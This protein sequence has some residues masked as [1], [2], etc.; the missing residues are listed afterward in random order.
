[1][2]FIKPVD[3]AP[4]SQRFGNDFQLP[5]GRWYNKQV[6]GYKGHNGN[7][8]AAASGTPVK[9]A[10]EGT[11]VFEGWGQNHSWM[12]QPAGI[13]VLIDNGGL[14]SGYAHLSDTVVNKGQHVEKGQ[15]IGHVGST[16]AATGPH[17]HFEALPK[18]PNFQNGFVGRVD[19]NPYFEAEAPTPQP[20]AG[21]QRVVGSPQGA[22][23]RSGAG[24]SFAPIQENG[25]PLV[26]DKGVVLN[27]KGYVHG[28]AV[29]GSDIWLVGISGTKYIHISNFDDTDLHDLSDLTPKQEQ[30]TT[31]I[32]DYSKLVLDVSS[33]QNDDIANHFEKFLGVIVRVGHVGKSYGGGETKTDPKYKTFVQ[34]A[35]NADK[36]LGL[37]WLPYIS[38]EEDAK[39]EAA[40]FVAAINEVGN[41]D[42]EILFVDL[43]PDFEGTF[44]QLQIFRNEVFKATGKSVCV[45]AGNTIA[46]KL[47]LELVQ[48]YPNYSTTNDYPRSAVLHQYTST[49]NV[50]GYTG[51]LD[52]STTNKP[53]KELRV[54][55]Q[56]I[57]PG[58]PEAPK[59]DDKPKE[60]P[61]PDKLANNEDEFAKK[62][63]LTRKEHTMTTK[64]SD[65]DFNKMKKDNELVETDGW[66]PTI[67]D[68]V[69]LV[70]YLMGVIGIPIT[71]MTMSLLAVFGVVSYE[72][73]NQVSTIIASAIG[74]IASA[75]G[76]SH[77]TRGKQ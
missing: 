71:V 45:Y 27:F 28:Q 50:S 75:L 77:F 38:T 34:A 56:K 26:Y 61:K 47:G 64:L 70:V 18:T 12:G 20:L 4:I 23:V 59:T 40:R 48:W 5:D 53:L 11:V 44:Q 52:F 60:Q 73:S 24:T 74:T 49:G 65:E 66:K 55:G 14:Y 46:E 37:Y 42:G 68:N 57:I 16:G 67:P 39:T 33:F 58:E 30:P 15:V 3:N 19:P 36:L 8:Y 7:D 10:D 29:N 1:M 54:F 22:L 31:P 43:E 2:S 21:N 41:V 13:C 72:L 63:S 25:K 32:V 69:R 9:A 17:L 51:N 6:L 35:R 76:I 62:P